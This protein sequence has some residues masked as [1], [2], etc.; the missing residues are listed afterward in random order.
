DDGRGRT[1]VLTGVDEAGERGADGFELRVTG[2][3]RGHGPSP[4][5]RKR[6]ARTLR[7]SNY[8]LNA[9][10]AERSNA[11]RC[12]GGAVRSWPC[13]IVQTIAPPSPLPSAHA[14]FAWI[15]C[16]SS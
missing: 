10:R 11:S 14:P 2:A 16:A 7:F 6:G 13:W 15:D 9:L 3:L 12:P 1:D 5:S 8:A 4:G